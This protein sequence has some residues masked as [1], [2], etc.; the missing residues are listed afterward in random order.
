MS[1]VYVC[2]RV[3]VALIARPLK[4]WK[5][6]YLTPPC[7][8]KK[9]AFQLNLLR[10][11]PFCQQS[12]AVE[13][14]EFEWFLVYF[15][16]FYRSLIL[17]FWTH[18]FLQANLLHVFLSSGFESSWTFMLYATHPYVH[19]KPYGWVRNDCTIIFWLVINEFNVNYLF[20]FY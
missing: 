17:K 4:A 8:N 5:D 12:Q 10:A 14:G 15:Y 9:N 1:T 18:V 11:S 6:L 2:S 19:I 13:D 7:H 20:Q 16:D 3:V